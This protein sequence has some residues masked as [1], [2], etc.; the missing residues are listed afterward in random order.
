MCASHATK[1]QKSEHHDENDIRGLP[2]GRS[3]VSIY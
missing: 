1:T 3:P 2:K